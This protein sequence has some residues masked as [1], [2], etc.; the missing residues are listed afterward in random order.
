[1]YDKIEKI[2]NSWD[3][4]DLFPLAPKDEY[5]Q[6]IKK[7]ISIV[8]TNPNIETHALAETLKNI[9]IESFGEE[10]MFKDNELE[11]AEKVLEIVR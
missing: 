1:M 6:E 3:P 8:E 2:I 5:S 11:I 9:F 7:I 4:I 10:M